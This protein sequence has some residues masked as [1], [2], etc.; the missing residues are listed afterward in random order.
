MYSDEVLND[1]TI[2][3]N[4]HPVSKWRR[5]LLYLGDMLIVFILSFAILN[6]AVVPIASAFI[7]TNSDKAY[8]AEKARDD[9]LY[10]YKLLFYK[11]NT[12]YKKYDYDQNLKYTF[13][14]FLAFYVFSNEESI[15]PDYPE[16]AHF[17]ENE[18]I[19]TYYHNIRNDDI[20]YYD[21][22]SKLNKEKNYF[23]VSSNSVTLKQPIKDELIVFYKPGESLGKKG[24]EYYNNL[25]DIFAALYGVVTQDIYDKDLVD[26][27]GNS[28]VKCQQIIAHV[29]SD[30]YK[31]IAICSII[32][33]T[34]SA[35]LVH[36][37]YPLINKSGHTPTSSIMKMDRLDFV[38]LQPL[39]KAEVALSSIYSILLDLP[40]IMF[41][42]LSYTTFIYSLKVPALPILSIISFVIVLISLFIIIFND[43]N[44]SGI[45][46]LSRTVM[47][48]TEEVDG[49]IKAQETIKELKM[50][51]LRKKREEDGQG[52]TGS[53]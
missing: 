28:F 19:Y 43:F 13:N 49:I 27:A 53:H 21:L 23:D 47:I 14:R 6:I 48:P 3:V 8:E 42:P 33:Y 50:A 5:I 20:T 22:F 40:C 18:I 39:N 15:N 45:D 29:A 41:V 9:I 52:S 24:E 12:D 51:E 1:K 36:L 16:Y 4:I 17:Q 7:K 2:E 32:A 44:R 46:L 31:T 26:S 38:H 34:I 37:L 10:E 35:L 11:D 30:Y 25:S